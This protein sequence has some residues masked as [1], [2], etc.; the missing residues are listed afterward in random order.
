MSPR[1][2]LQILSEATG[3]ERLAFSRNEHKTILDALE[4][5]RV[6]TIA[7]ENHDQ[8]IEIQP[9]VRAPAPTPEPK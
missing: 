9:L 1:T 6:A 3:D 4:T 7:G 8:Q 2:A 5:L